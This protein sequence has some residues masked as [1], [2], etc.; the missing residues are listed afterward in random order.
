VPLSI[1]RGASN[2]AGDRDHA[3]WKVAPALRACRA[4]LERW[5]EGFPK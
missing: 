2:E 4:A 3:G 5:V 1:V